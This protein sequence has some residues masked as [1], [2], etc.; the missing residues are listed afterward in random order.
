MVLLLQ[1]TI[2][3][4]YLYDIYHSFLYLLDRRCNRVYR[5]AMHTEFLGK[6]Q[7]NLTK[8]DKLCKLTDIYIE[9]RV[10]QN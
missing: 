5:G 1:Q 4:K 8:L 2:F 7:N 6:N 10:C 3:S 9:M